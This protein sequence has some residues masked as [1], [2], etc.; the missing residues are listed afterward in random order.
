M[1]FDRPITVA[2]E[3]KN[4]LKLY[5]PETMGTEVGREFILAGWG[6]SGQ[7]NDWGSENHYDRGMQ[8]LHRGYNHVDDVRDNLITYTMD[9]Q[10]EGG[11]ELEVSGH[12]GDSGSGALIE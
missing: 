10:S 12:Q 4:Y 11:H 3:G 6:T 8:V 7:M 5:N 9:R 2:K 1:I